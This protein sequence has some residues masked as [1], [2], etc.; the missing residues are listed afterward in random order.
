MRQGDLLVEHGLFVIKS[1]F[2]KYPKSIDIPKKVEYAIGMFVRNLM[3]WA[4]FR[5]LH[6]E[7]I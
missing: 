4:L 5:Y 1:V 7:E 6:P 3:L 2:D